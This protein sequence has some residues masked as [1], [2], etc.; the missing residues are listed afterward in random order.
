MAFDRENPP[1]ITPVVG[2]LLATN[3]I[4]YLLQTRTEAPIYA[5]FGLWP[6][7]DTGTRPDFQ[8][9]QILTY[10]WLHGGGAHIFFNLFAVWMFGKTIELVW[11]SKRFLIYY[12]VCV[13]GAGF[14]QL[15]VTTQMAATTGRVV[16]TVGA[17]GGVFGILLAFAVLFPNQKILLLIPP[18]PIKAKFFVIGY[19]ALEL[20]LGITQ[21][22]SGVAHFAHLGGMVFGFILIRYWVFQRK[23]KLNREADP[24]E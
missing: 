22:N 17:S 2:F 5:L 12:L 23:R 10:G 9:W 3:V 16:G 11:G 24:L 4:V 21:T 18:I 15:V 20:Y 8:F 6:L 19:G 7:H 1:S 13:V 14:V